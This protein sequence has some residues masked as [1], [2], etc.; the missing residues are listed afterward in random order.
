MLFLLTTTTV[1]SLYFDSKFQIIAPTTSQ[2]LSHFWGLKTRK[3]DFW[4]QQIFYTLQYTDGKML[5]VSNKSICN[6]F[7]LN[8]SYLN[9]I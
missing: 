3:S 4:H 2:F 9:H 1:Q 5:A 7:F 6:G 8:V